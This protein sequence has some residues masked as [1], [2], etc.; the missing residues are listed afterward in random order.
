MRLLSWLA[1]NSTSK[2]CS[3]RRNSSGC[4]AISLC[5]SGSRSQF[6][7]AFGLWK[8]KKYSIFCHWSCRRRKRNE[9]TACTLSV[10]PGASFPDCHVKHRLGFRWRSQTRIRCCPLTSKHDQEAFWK[11]RCCS[12][13]LRFSLIMAAETSNLWIIEHL[14][15]NCICSRLFPDTSL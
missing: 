4:F 3:W 11:V 5:S 9:S 8:P 14:L 7:H 2:T 13:N 6:I 10:T 12:F 15:I 1:P